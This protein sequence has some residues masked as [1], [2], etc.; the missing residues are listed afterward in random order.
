MVLSR[1]HKRSHRIFLDFC[2]SQKILINDIETTI[3]GVSKVE[4]FGARH[5]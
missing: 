3:S 2:L 1:F 5:R 4:Q